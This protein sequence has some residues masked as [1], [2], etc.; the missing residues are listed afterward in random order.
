MINGICATVTNKKRM[1][2]EKGSLREC[3]LKSER[4]RRN[5]FRGAWLRMT[6][7]MGCA[8]GI[9]TL[10]TRLKQQLERDHL[11]LLLIFILRRSLD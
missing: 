5:S 3:V 2:L 6:I 4:L 8:G 7:S 10:A 9:D 1:G 11:P